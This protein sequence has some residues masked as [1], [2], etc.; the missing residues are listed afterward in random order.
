VAANT[1]DDGFR[2]IQLSGK[3]LI[4]LFMAVTVAGVVV[5]LTGVMVGRDVRSERARMAQATAVTE[6]PAPDVVS[7]SPSP[8][9]QTVVATV[10]PK[11]PPPD[12]VDD[13]SEKTAPAA[14]PEPAATKPE[15]PAA[16]PAP[17]PAPV[18]VAA[19]PTPPPPPA[20]STQPPP[21]SAAK[22]AATAAAADA[23][24]AGAPGAGFAVQVAA[25]N[26]RSEADAIAKRLSAKGYS[27]YV[28]TPSNGSTSVFRVRV[29]SFKTRREAESVAARLQK[30]EQFK[31]WVTR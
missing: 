26:V 27:A 22:P 15:P 21:A 14:K 6:T 18:A 3:Q 11:T 31:P 9:S 23:G 20:K 5:F 2:E 7:M 24:E 16:K 25:L 10:D 30:E 1:Q 4:F 28:Q 17:A 29:G 12:P 19:K 8:P 13:P